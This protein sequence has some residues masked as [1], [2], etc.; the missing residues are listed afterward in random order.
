MPYHKQEKLLRGDHRNHAA[1]QLEPGH[2]EAQYN[3]G[4][5]L[6]VQRKPDEAIAGLPIWRSSSSPTTPRPIATW[7]FIL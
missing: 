2:A 7:G 6:I 4:R 3:L 1:I 5:A